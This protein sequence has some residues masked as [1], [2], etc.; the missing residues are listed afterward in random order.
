MPEDEAPKQSVPGWLVEL[1][2]EHRKNQ[3]QQ[4]GEEGYTQREA[5]KDVVIAQVIEHAGPLVDEARRRGF[6][7]VRCDTNRDA[8]SLPV[9]IQFA[10]GKGQYYQRSLAIAKVA[11]THG[12]NVTLS[13]AV[14]VRVA[15][16][17]HLRGL[18]GFKG[19]ESNM[20][21]KRVPASG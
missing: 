7:F 17:N 12:L 15:V 3:I 20:K 2:D 21:K 16:E 8:L 11:A 6:T 4:Y 10:D 18:E 9:L 19:I 13:D 5:V 14:D 1:A